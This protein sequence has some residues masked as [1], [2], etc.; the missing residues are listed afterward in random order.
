MPNSDKSVGNP[1]LDVVL[2][3]ES[4]YLMTVKT[5]KDELSWS[6]QRRLVNNYFRARKDSNVAN[7]HIAEVP[8][9][10]MVSSIPAPKPVTFYRK[11]R[12]KIAAICSSYSIDEKDLFDLMFPFIEEEYDLEEAEIR[13][14]AGTGKRLQNKLDLFDFFPDIAEYAKKIIDYLYK[15]KVEH[16]EEKNN[17]SKEV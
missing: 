11:N 15:V 2:L 5:F 16:R 12:Y 8:Q 17:G 4:G 6:V 10:M 13:Y 3:T 7:N 9:R 1:N 14:I